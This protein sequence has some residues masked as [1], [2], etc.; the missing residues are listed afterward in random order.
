MIPKD[1][2]LTFAYYPDKSRLREVLPFKTRVQCET[3]DE[4]TA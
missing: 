4:T 1:F 3:Y 2:T